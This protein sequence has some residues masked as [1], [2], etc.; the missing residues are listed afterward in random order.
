MISRKRLKIKVTTKD[1]Y[2]YLLIPGALPQHAYNT[3]FNIYIPCVVALGETSISS[4]LYFSMQN[5]EI[6]CEH[7]TLGGVTSTSAN[8][9]LCLLTFE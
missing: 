1:S 4:C 2:E 6:S 5:I 9:C 3:C 7:V 8:N